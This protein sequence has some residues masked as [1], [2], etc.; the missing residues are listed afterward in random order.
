MLFFLRDQSYCAYKYE[1]FWKITKKHM[2]QIRDY[3]RFH[4]FWVLRP[5]FPF[6]D[7]FLIGFKDLRDLSFP[8]IF[9]PGV[10][11]TATCGQSTFFFFGF[12]WQF[13]DNLASASA[14][15]F[16]FFQKKLVFLFLYLSVFFVFALVA[17]LEL[18]FWSIFFW[19]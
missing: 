19:N 3:L 4:D 11:K 15:F 13:F 16:G 7:G 18:L 14:P 5:S 1:V 12:F 9:G 2:F 8:A 10:R 17:N 6:F